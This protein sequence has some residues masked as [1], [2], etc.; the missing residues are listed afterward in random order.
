MNK[1]IA[2]S[3]AIVFLSSNC[4]A[5]SKTTK[6]VLGIGVMAAGV[7]LVIDG[8]RQVKDT[9][10]S[11]EEST[12][13]SMVTKSGG[14]ASVQKVSRHEKSGAE[15]CAGIAALVAG[16]VMTIRWD[17][18]SQCPIVGAQLQF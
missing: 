12:T 10:T 1:T 9:E 5:M 6:T 17:K 11:I 13:S 16:S 8:A 7:I 3:L 2:L 14:Y 4:F 15:V 18:D